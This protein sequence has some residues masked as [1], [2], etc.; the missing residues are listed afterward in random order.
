M[1]FMELSRLK[2]SVNFKRIADSDWLCWDMD[3]RLMEVKSGRNVVMKKLWMEISDWE[4]NCRH[5]VKELQPMVHGGGF[6]YECRV[7]NQLC[8]VSEVMTKP[9]VVPEDYA[10]K[11]PGP[12]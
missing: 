5:P 2:T 3:G 1:T 7:C 11:R 6:E 10:M 12:I 8:V 4:I 9:P